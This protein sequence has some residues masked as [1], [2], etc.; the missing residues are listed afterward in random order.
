[1]FFEKNKG[2]LVLK[3]LKIHEIILIWSLPKYAYNLIRFDR[4][5]S[6]F[7]VGLSRVVCAGR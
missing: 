1:M 6:D 4:F 5:A 3:Q 2:A 7:S